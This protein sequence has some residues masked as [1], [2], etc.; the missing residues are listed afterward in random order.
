[1]KKILSLLLLLSTLFAFVSC[2]MTSSE[3]DDDYDTTKPTS[4]TR[5]TTTTSG[6]DWELREYI[7]EF[8]RPTGDKFIQ[9]TVSGTFSNS[10]TTGS[11]LKATVQVTKDSIAIMLWEYGS[12]LVKGTFDTNNYSIT[13]LDQN[14][15]KHYYS[16][17]MYEDGTRIYVNDSYRSELLSY[18]KKGGEISFYLVYS[19]Y[20][21]STYSFTISTKGFSSLYSQL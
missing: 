2:D 4:S 1:M 10:A 14:D 6:S 9:T 19:K 3:L 18:L 16:G 15:T 11:T 5:T 12:H 7:D 20:S 17:Y 8:D 21:K 13:I